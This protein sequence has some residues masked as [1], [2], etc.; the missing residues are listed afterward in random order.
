MYKDFSF[1]KQIQIIDPTSLTNKIL[2]LL[3]S[4][5]RSNPS[6]QPNVE[7]QSENVDEETQVIS[8]LIQKEFPRRWRGA[9]KYNLSSK[10]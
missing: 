1:I 3:Q 10:K 8:S 9:V 5:Y 6:A 4:A 2:L 7:N